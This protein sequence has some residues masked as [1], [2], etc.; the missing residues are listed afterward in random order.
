M[1]KWALYAKVKE[2]SDQK[3]QEKMDLLEEGY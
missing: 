3:D 2:E 1:K